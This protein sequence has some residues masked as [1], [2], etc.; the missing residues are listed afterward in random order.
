MK[1][2][3]TIN[4]ARDHQPVVD[5]LRGLT[6]VPSDGARLE[7]FLGGDVFLAEDAAD[8]E[9]IYNSTVVDHWEWLPDG[10]HIVLVQIT[11]NSGGPTYVIP[12]EF[13]VEPQDDEPSDDV[14]EINYDPYS[15]CDT[16]ETYPIDEP[17]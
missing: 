17:F 5:Y 8:A 12:E 4:Q 10:T 13:A 16:F 9:F 1:H 15:G 7:L 14:S 6:L 3:T 2:F 11:N